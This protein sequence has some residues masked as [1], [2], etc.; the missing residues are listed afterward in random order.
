LRNQQQLWQLWVSCRHIKKKKPGEIHSLWSGH[1]EILRCRCHSPP[2]RCWSMDQAVVR[3]GCQVSGLQVGGSLFTQ[4]TA[5]GEPGISLCFARGFAHCPDG[6]A[7]RRKRAHASLRA[8]LDP[9]PPAKWERRPSGTTRWGH[10]SRFFFFFLPR[11]SRGT[12][13]L[14]ARTIINGTS[15]SQLGVK[16]LATSR[17][18]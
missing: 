12:T 1:T 4:P 5:G 10:A 17:Y 16:Y 18:S 7:F 15:L 2:T 8:R 11:A 14:L 6:A 9:P 13:S 3:S